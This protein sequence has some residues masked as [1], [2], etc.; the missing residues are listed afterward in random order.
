M[1]Y[2]KVLNISDREID[3][4]EPLGT[5]WKF[6]YD[7]PDGRAYLFKA[8]RA[9]GP[10]GKPV[11]RYG[12]DWAEKIVSEVAHKLDIPCVQYELATYEGWNGVITPIMTSDGEEL[13]HGNQLI[14]NYLNTS[15]MVQAVDN[16]AHTVQIVIA[17]LSDG[18]ILKPKNWRSLPG[19]KLP[20]DF[21]I[22][23]L[24][25][26]TLV[27]NQDR[28]QQNWGVIQTADATVHLSPTFDHAASLGR[29]E[30]D[31]RREQILKAGE[32][33]F[34]IERYVRRAKSLLYSNGV[35][36]KTI[37]AFHEFAVVSESA[38]DSWLEKLDK[39]KESEIVDIVQKVPCGIMTDMSKDFC[40]SLIKANKSRL[41]G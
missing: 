30:S 27:S 5:K 18:K 32:R 25:L 35:K 15:S 20:L 24:L 28:H 16:S 40:I 7:D 12:E 8:A 3:N 29:N 26:D 33:G 13:V 37:D 6:W 19:I 38:K 10:E 9:D 14:N 21:F 31:E 41:L 36:L 39:L 34:N 23:Y 11:L 2:Y 4:I 17:T 22:G 1:Q